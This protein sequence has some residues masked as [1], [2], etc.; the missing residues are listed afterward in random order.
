MLR[1]VRMIF[2]SVLD[3][4]IVETLRF[5]AARRLA[6]TIAAHREPHR[7]RGRSAFELRR[8]SAC[9]AAQHSSTDRRARVRFMYEIYG[10]VCV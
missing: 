2:N 4:F 5:T 1:H 9:G 6:S 10:E 7:R 8:C 3:G